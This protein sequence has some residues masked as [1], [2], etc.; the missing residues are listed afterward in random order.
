MEK[1]RKQEG[2]FDR[3]QRKGIY[4]YFYNSIPAGGGN[5]P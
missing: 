5:A 1:K 3:I 2:G 4:I